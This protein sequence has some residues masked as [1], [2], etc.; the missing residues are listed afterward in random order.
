LNAAIPPPITNNMRLPAN[1]NVP[2]A[3]G[4]AAP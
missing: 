1:M 4:F 3:L 2:S